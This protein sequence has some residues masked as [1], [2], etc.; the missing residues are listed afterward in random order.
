MMPLSTMHAIVAILLAIFGLVR[1][2]EDMAVEPWHG[3]TVRDLH[4]MY[5]KIFKYGNRNAASHLWASFLI[6]RSKTMS[7]GKLK[8]LF[9]GFCAVSGSPTRPSPYSKYSMEIDSVTGKKEKGITVFC[10]WPCVCDTNDWIKIDTKTVETSDGPKQFRFMVIGN[11]CKDPD[12][13]PWEAPEVR[14][15]SSGNL[16]G[17]TVSDHGFIIISMFFDDDGT[18]AQEE[19][20]YDGYCKERAENGYNS[21]MG[22][23]FRKVAMIN[24]IRQ[25]L[26]A[27]DTGVEK[28]EG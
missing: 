4:Q 6:D 23:I 22:E 15:D 1:A 9:E 18:A 11:P 20:M 28:S 17:A 5:S 12:R 2:T 14:C 26:L 7:E 24:P 10:C 21:G 16:E 13:I 8:S 25:T 19:S 3:E 27:P